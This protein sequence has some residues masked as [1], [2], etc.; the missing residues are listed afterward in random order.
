M[1]NYMSRTPITEDD[2]GLL[3]SWN[4]D[5]LNLFIALANGNNGLSQPRMRITNL[6]AITQETIKQDIFNFMRIVTD[7][8]YRPYPESDILFAPN[9][10]AQHSQLTF[11][12]GKLA[13]DPWIQNILRMNPRIQLA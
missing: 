1:E 11:Q 12:L 5:Y 2:P 4:S 3:L 9:T 13:D 10:L 6:G 8:F 7:R